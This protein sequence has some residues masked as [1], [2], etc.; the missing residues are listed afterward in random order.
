MRQVP[1]SGSF[2]AEAQ[3]VRSPSR[4]S[5]AA[6]PLNVDMSGSIPP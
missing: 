4:M 5:A 3:P 2:G 1:N 6:V